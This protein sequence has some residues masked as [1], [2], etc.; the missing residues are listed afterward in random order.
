MAH[1]SIACLKSSKDV[2]IDLVPAQMQLVT[3]CML[4]CVVLSPLRGIIK[5]LWHC[6]HLLGKRV[7]L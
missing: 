4:C 7:A 6:K 3:L 1:F 2:N 5:A